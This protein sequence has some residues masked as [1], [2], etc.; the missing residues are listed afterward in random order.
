MQIA[1]GLAPH[2]HRFT[3]QHRAGVQSLFH[4]HHHHAG[5]AVAGHDRALNGRGSPPSRQQRCVQIETAQSRRLKNGFGENEPVGH[6][7]C[8]IQTERRKRCLFIAIAQCRR[9]PHREACALR[10]LVHRRFLLRE[11][12]ALRP[13]RLRVHADD[14][15]GRCYQPGKHRNRKIRRPH[16][17]YPH[18]YQPLRLSFADLR[19]AIERFNLERWSMNRRPLMWSISC[20]RQVAN[21]PSAETTSLPPFSFR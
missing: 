1:R 6:H 14:L 5:L 21:R 12:T 4:A 11:S 19:S 18:G 16:K 8:C 2:R 3:H 17:A 9:R 13:G 20:C 10:H 7:H 15:M